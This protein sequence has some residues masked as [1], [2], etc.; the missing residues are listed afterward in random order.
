MSAFSCQ[1]CKTPLKLDDS[2]KNLN[3]AAFD[4][5]TGTKPTDKTSNPPAKT[6][7]PADRKALYD[8]SRKHAGQAVHQQ[9]TPAARRGIGLGPSKPGHGAAPDMSFVVL[10][11]SQVQPPPR[12]ASSPSKDGKTKESTPSG[13]DVPHETL[14]NKLEA[15]N[16][17]FEILSAHSEID[18]PVCIDCSEILLSQFQNRLS[19][20][21][22]ERDEL[23][24]QVP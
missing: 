23:S 4:L 6:T 3:S 14:S 22:K 13:L 17:L 9:G 15:H 20:S 19:A 16:R 1:R 7:I 8:Q 18:H 2:L 10:T 12:L 5:L 11:E 21:T 24:H